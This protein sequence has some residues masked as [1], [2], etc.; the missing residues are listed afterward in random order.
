MPRKALFFFIIFVCFSRK[1][2]YKKLNLERSEWVDID[3]DA[4]NTVQYGRVH[5]RTQRLSAC[6]GIFDIFCFRWNFIEIE[7]ANSNSPNRLCHRPRRHR[8]CHGC[9]VYRSRNAK[10]IGLVHFFRFELKFCKDRFSSPPDYTARSSA[11][12]NKL[13]WT[14]TTKTFRTL[15]RYYYFF[16]FSSCSLNQINYPI[17]L[18]YP[19]QHTRQLKVD[20]PGES[21]PVK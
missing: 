7:L 1:R 11:Q 19:L 13:I 17:T 8:H 4:R 18:H 20:L 5:D 16:F 14:R 6:V 10:E 12:W 15:H 21:G 2:K 9:H 3:D